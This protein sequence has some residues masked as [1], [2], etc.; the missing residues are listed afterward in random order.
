MKY[1]YHLLFLMSLLAQVLFFPLAASALEPLT[2]KPEGSTYYIC[3][4]MEILE[5]PDKALG[6]D[7]IVREKYSSRFIQN[8]KNFISLGL[9][10]SAFWLR[11]KLVEDD[12]PYSETPITNQHTDWFLKVGNPCLDNIDLYIPVDQD[13]QNKGYIIKKTGAMRP[14]DT[15]EIKY[16]SFIFTLP[17]NIK[18]DTFFYIR[19]ESTSS[20][21]TH[22]EILSDKAFQQNTIKDNIGFGILYGI[23]ISMALFNLFLFISLRDVTYIYYVLH[24][25]SD[26]LYKIFL[27]GHIRILSNQLHDIERHLL[28]LFLAGSVFWAGAFSKAFLSTKTNTPGLDKMFTL[29]M[30]FA[31]VISGVGFW[32]SIFKPILCHT[33]WDLFR[34]LSAY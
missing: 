8:T 7:E 6:F 5:D 28:F 1:C 23:I 27:Y 2:I 34:Y 21:N 11:F 15:Q 25:L 14:S 12:T 4:Y 17:A 18:H 9:S 32:D 26:V 29:L 3:P 31:V 30:V 10:K 20:L 13:I 33:Y 19:I 16:R 22:I 24:I